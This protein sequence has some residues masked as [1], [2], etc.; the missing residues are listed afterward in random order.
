MLKNK[1]TFTYQ[2]K[3]WESWTFDVETKQLIYYNP[4]VFKEEDCPANWM[5][6]DGYIKK[7]EDIKNTM[8][9]SRDEDG[10]LHFRPISK[11]SKE[12]ISNILRDATNEENGQ[13]INKK[14]WKAIKVAFPSIY[15]NF[16]DRIERMDV[17]W[18]INATEH[19][20]SIKK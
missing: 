11:L 14:V 13:G 4:D 16:E 19:L 17:I 12:H 9:G 10:D 8:W 5:T 6:L 18:Y 1:K 7:I 20:A 15:K 2:G 3:R